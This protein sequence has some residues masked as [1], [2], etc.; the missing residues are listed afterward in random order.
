MTKRLLAAMVTTLLLLVPEMAP[1]DAVLDLKAEMDK[2]EERNRHLEEEI[3]KQKEI[4]D[5]LSEKVKELE[6]F[7]A[8]LLDE[9]VRGGKQVLLPEKDPESHGLMETSRLKIGGFADIG[10]TARSSKIE[11]SKMF[12]LGELDLFMRSEISQKVSFLAELVFYP[13]Q[14]NP[15]FSL[16][17]Q[18][19]ILRYALS[20]LLN[21]TV[22]RMHTAL[23]YWND[24][25]HHG[26][27]LH[28]TI[29]RPEIYRFEYNSGVLPVH[30]VGIELSGNKELH[31]LGVAYHLGLINGRARTAA[32]VHN[33]IDENDAKA[34]NVLLS[35][36]PSF[37]EGLRLGGT[38]YIDTIPPNP[39]VPERTDQ[40]D[41][42]IVG[43]H[44]VYLYNNAE[45]LGE[46]FKI[47]HHD[48]TS[49]SDF[50]SLGYY[51]QGGYRLDEWTPYYRFDFVN[52]KEEDP[53]FSPLQRDI[54]KDTFGLRWDILTWNTLKIEYGLSRVKGVDREHSFSFNSSVAF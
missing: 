1:A 7:D 26:T 29:Y 21:I 5:R 18:R 38:L 50:D 10:F 53:F 12:G 33:F 9:E 27:W 54:R 52:L 11:H 40:I 8:V 17:F 51:V 49:G 14:T 32:T 35:L 23:G 48:R 28:A 20:D 2:I 4:T 30:A 41:E 6:N 43:A 16:D 25:Y 47:H 22:G 42:R 3:G 37:A 46:V 34:F 15:R 13:F 45:I 36:K 31:W 39:A 44:L 19:L 24:A